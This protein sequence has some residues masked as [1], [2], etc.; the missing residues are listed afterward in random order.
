MVNN[1]MIKISGSLALLLSVAG[2]LLAVGGQFNFLGNERLPTV[3]QQKVVQSENKPKYN[4]Y[5]EL[6]RRKA[7]T[8]AANINATVARNLPQKN[9]D[10]TTQA[11]S[12]EIKGSAENTVNKT[13]D[14]YQYVV[15]VGAFS[16]AVDAE[17]V[18]KRVIELGYPGRVVRGTSGGR[19]FLAQA[20]PFQGKEKARSIQEVLKNQSM[21]TLIKRLK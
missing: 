21:P 15:Q 1:K 12:K 6:K 11:N 14:S 4:F 18:K 17:K 5:D 9:Q 3:K 19:K 10:T 7:E 20:G 16:K 2:V 13:T 8:D